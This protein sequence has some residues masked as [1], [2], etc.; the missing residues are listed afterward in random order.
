MKTDSVIRA[1]ENYAFDTLPARGLEDVEAALD[2]Q[3]QH[4]F[5]LSLLRY[6]G[7]MH[8]AVNSG[9]GCFQR[10]NV[11]DVRRVDFFAGPC[12]PERGDVGEANKRLAA[13]QALAQRVAD[14]ASS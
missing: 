9:H 12:R 4:L 8:D 13:A 2:I 11:T 10:S 14:L 5:P 6:A 3:R 1:S 7:E